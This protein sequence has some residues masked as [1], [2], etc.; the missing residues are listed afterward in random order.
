MRL[1]KMRQMKDVGKIFE[2]KLNSGKKE[3]NK[4]VWEKINTSLE[5]ERL[6]KKRLLYKWLVGGVLFST[7]VLFLLFNNENLLQSN[8]PKNQNDIPVINQSDISSEE[9][10]EQKDKSNN[11]KELFEVLDDSTSMVGTEIQKEPSQYTLSGEN[12][13]ISEK[14]NSSETNIQIQSTDAWKNAEKKATHNEF[15]DK[16]FSVSKIYHYY[17]SKD[18]KTIV[19]KNRN[20]IDSLISNQNKYSDSLTTRKNDSIDQ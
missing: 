11:N 19:T 8:S 17:N 16:D 1:I 18:N 9:S 7:L 6:R 15:N 5:A 12:P 2:N 13:E 20:E 14:E 4:N 3:P 10:G